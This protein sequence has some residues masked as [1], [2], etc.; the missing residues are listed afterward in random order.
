MPHSVVENEYYRDDNFRDQFNSYEQMVMDAV[1]PSNA[2]YIMQDTSSRSDYQTCNVDET[3]NENAQAFCDILSTAQDPLYPKCEVKSELSTAVRM[4][5]IKSDY[6]ILEGGYNEIMQFM[7]QKMPTGNNVPSD[8][9]HTKKLVSQLELG[10]QKIDYYSNRCILYY[11]D[12]ESEM[13]CKFCGHPR[14][15]PVRSG[16]EKF[17]QIS[18]KKKCG[19][20]L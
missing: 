5:S 11:K 17:K 13:S 12:Y 4:L 14:F 18:Y 10:Y 15:K 7:H 8:F 16:K 19:I 1:G 9:Y 20:C 3:L 2:P 6:N